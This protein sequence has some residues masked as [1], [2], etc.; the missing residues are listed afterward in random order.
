MQHPGKACASLVGIEPARRRQASR[1]EGDIVDGRI[2]RRRRAADIMGMTASTVLITKTRDEELKTMLEELR[3]ELVREVHVRIRAARTEHGHAGIG[4]DEAE[5]SDVDIQ[6]EIGF[7]L[8]QMKTE[9]LDKINTALRRIDEGTYGVC[10]ECGDEIA[11]PRLRAL[12]FAVRCK[13]C[14]ETREM[15]ERRERITARGRSAS[16]FTDMPS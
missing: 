8:I 16:L 14:E 1:R 13:D 10:F 15:A 2:V 6:E 12:P 7:T 5:A 9:A 3:R 4:L 11:G